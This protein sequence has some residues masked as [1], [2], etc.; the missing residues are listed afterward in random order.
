MSRLKR[1]G[2]D[3]DALKKRVANK[4]ADARLSSLF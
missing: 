2:E 1:I 4:R 3:M